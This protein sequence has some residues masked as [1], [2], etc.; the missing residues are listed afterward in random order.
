[1]ATVY[2]IWDREKKAA[3]PGTFASSADAN[4]AR[5]P[6]CVERDSQ[7]QGEYPRCRGGDGLT[8]RLA[9]AEQARGRGMGYLGGPF[10]YAS[11]TVV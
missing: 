7:W 5:S 1:M 10:L 2:I 11:V 9:V 4:R 6:S 8:G 3:V